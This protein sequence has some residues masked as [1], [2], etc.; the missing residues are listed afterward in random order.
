MKK[1]TWPQV[2]QRSLG[3]LGLIAS[4]ILCLMAKGATVLIPE[5]TMSY[6]WALFPLVAVFLWLVMS[7]RLKTPYVRAGW[8][9]GFFTV[10]LLASCLHMVLD[11]RVFALP[12]FAS[13]IHMY[14]TFLG[15]PFVLLIVYFGVSHV[16]TSYASSRAQFDPSELSAYEM[17]IGLLF[18]VL[19]LFMANLFTIKPGDDAKKAIQTHFT[20]LKLEVT[21][22]T[23][24]YRHGPHL[25]VASDAGLQH[26]YDG[27]A[28]WSHQGK[29]EGLLTDYVRK[30]YARGD[31]LLIVLDS[32]DQSHGG[33][34]ESHDEG[35]SWQ[36]LP[37]P[38]DAASSADA[39][40]DL[41]CERQGVCAYAYTSG[42]EHVSIRSPQTQEFE[43]LTG[44]GKNS[45][46]SSVVLASDA[47]NIFRLEATGIWRSQDEGKHWE[48]LQE[49][50]KTIRS[51]D[52]ASALR[53]K[54]PK[55]GS[56]SHHGEEKY[57]EDVAYV[58]EGYS[59]EQK[60]ILGL[61]VKG[62]ELCLVQRES[63]RHSKD[64]GLNWVRSASFPDGISSFVSFGSLGYGSSWRGL[65]VF[66]DDC[67]EPLYDASYGRV[68]KVLDGREQ[69]LIK[70]E[71]GLFVSPL[72]AP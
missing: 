60:E 8:W 48:F 2:W 31:S 24:Y 53:P 13:Q 15:A 69:V 9:K 16:L 51:I 40:Q 65:A 36:S 33:L 34:M 55:H 28:T 70:S 25:I 42:L 57:G 27:G 47:N 17:V 72:A 11:L 6:R 4:L 18:L 5:L 14:S 61:T 32:D 59:D 52:R 12:Q 63:L 46:K 43:T 23:G 22:P 66:A 30:L 19:G 49:K 56:A 68:E 35:K 41:V 71:K 64:H 21:D 20:P 39:W 7:L 62:E 29:A 54:E 44:P 26:S 3:L 1:Y 10:F 38:K 50:E 37:D 67:S 45:T 58:Q